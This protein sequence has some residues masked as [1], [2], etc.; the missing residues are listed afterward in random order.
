V[1]IVEKNAILLS[2]GHGFGHGM[3][4]CQYGADALAQSGWHAERILKF[5]YPD[6]HLA[7]AY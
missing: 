7:R 6:S 5:Y 3:G 4:L 2:N 1:P